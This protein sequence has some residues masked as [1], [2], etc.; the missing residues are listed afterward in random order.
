MENRYVCSKFR[1]LPLSAV[2]LTAAP[3]LLSGLVACTKKDES[4]S[5][6][7]VLPAAT[8]IGGT[9]VSA[10]GGTVIA[11]SGT[12]TGPSW[13]TSLNPASGSEI[14]CFAVFVGAE[15]PDL[16]VNSCD[17]ST[18]GTSST[19]KFGPYVGFVPGGQSVAINNVPAGPGRTIT[20]VG[21][22][23]QG[24]ACRDFTGTEVDAS[25][26]SQPFVIASQVADLRGGDNQVTI[27]AAL[28]SSKTVTTCA[29][30]RGPAASPTPSGG[31]FGDKRDGKLT[32]GGSTA[33]T[34]VVGTDT[35]GATD[36]THIAAVGGT[37]TTK[38]L[39]AT[40]GIT[41]V[42]TTGS[43]A[44]KL[45][46]VGTAFSANEFEAGDE[47][48]WHV[49]NGRSSA[50]P[51]DDPDLG[52]CGGELFLGRWGTAKIQSIPS[53]TSILLESAIL[54]TPAKVK[55]SNLTATTAAPDFCRISL[56]RVPNF[57]E[58]N[59]PVGATWTIE[60]LQYSPVA[61]VG[62]IIA[63]RTKKL[64]VDG[65]LTLKTDSMGYVPTTAGFQGPSLMGIGMT[66]P[67]AW[68]AGGGGSTTSSGGA[69]GANAGSGGQGSG[70]MGGMPHGFCGQNTSVALWSGPK[71]VC[72]RTSAGKT[73]CWGENQSNQNGD[74]VNSSL[75][76][77]TE[78]Y[79]LQTFTTIS[80]GDQHGCGI[81][82]GSSLFC[83]GG[84]STYQLGTNDTSARPT[85][86]PIDA[87]VVFSTVSAGTGNTCAVTVAGDLKCWGSNI[88]GQLGDGSTAPRPSPGP[89]IDTGYSTVAVG[90]HHTCG[91][92]SGG[93]LYCWGEGAGYRLG[94]GGTGPQNSPVL[95]DT[96]VNYSKVALS[97]TG[98]FGSTC[99][100]TTAGVLK[101]WGMN[102]LGQLGVGDTADKP[103]PTVVGSSY[104]DV[105]IGQTH[106][107]A[108][109]TAGVLKCWGQ[110]SNGELGT[111]GGSSLSPVVVDSGVSY[112]SVRAGIT[113]TCAMTTSGLVK[114]W[115]TGTN[116]QTGTGIRGIVATPKL[117]Q[118]TAVCAPIADQ[119][120]YMGGGGGGG[121]T[122]I[123][124]KGGGI[125]LVF[126]KEISGTGNLNLKALGGNG[127]AGSPGGAGGGAGG[128]I[129]LVT[130]SSNM[131]NMLFSAPGGNGG[132]G[133]TLGS[134]GG[135]G[136]VEL[137]YCTTQS[138]LASIGA[139]SSSLSGGTGF[140]GGSGA[141]GV[142]RDSV[143][144]SLCSAE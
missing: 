63:L 135:G 45:L 69:G 93:S 108:I 23:S 40:R 121:S 132:T 19:I 35:F 64:V 139:S 79:N 91:I 11:Q 133:S 106:A 59:V 75:S 103:T 1:G 15:Q 25:N 5:I 6:R 94:D 101:C 53:S 138:N 116:G 100:I 131:S 18:A 2:L 66:L 42:A 47:V 109:T 20:V 95:I 71:T 32:L 52:A 54:A 29:F 140:I 16:S 62:G 28:D 143:D 142:F 33:R 55:N 56:H 70:T 38:N 127:G 98:S 85:P 87:G 92:K 125:V 119:K 105:S 72:S 49:G 48:L 104:A 123:G 110:N 27:Q 73:F 50:G 130:R 39:S 134:G 26:L 10:K 117:A 112:V 111:G 88:Y 22:K 90:A 81:D 124:G 7:I 34:L 129:G 58:I 137:K 67:D 128:S 24:T 96:G 13:N 4:S 118:M 65:T 136:V 89:S 115:G 12:G 43:N 46:V 77:P 3:I 80:V 41:N 60:G 84:N 120:V 9:G 74:I 99:A 107:C 51:P 31:S 37:T 14:N 86:V 97:Q 114:C 21:L 144:A 113:H 61:G 83:W 68:G 76:A 57:E 82:S 78:S 36:A 141:K 122:T 30:I 126:A 102:S 44:G 8:S 17:I